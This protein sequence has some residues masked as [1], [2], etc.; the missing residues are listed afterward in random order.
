MEEREAQDLFDAG[1][2]IGPEGPHGVVVRAAVVSDELRADIG[3]AV[4]V[5]I[6]PIGDRLTAT[7]RDAVQQ[8]KVTVQHAALVPY[9]GVW[10]GPAGEAWIASDLCESGS[11][12]DVLQLAGVSD[13]PT[14]ER[15]AAYVIRNLLLAVDALH[16]ASS[17]HGDVCIIRSSTSSFR[18]SL[19]CPESWLLHTVV[20]S[21]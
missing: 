15:I 12:A 16:A 7:L 20:S 14:L 10:P 6:V 11:I 5:K 4:A 18:V 19:L 8:L 9:H 13:P 17:V 2:I 1:R 3:P 21:R